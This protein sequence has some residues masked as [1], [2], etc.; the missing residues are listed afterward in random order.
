MDTVAL[1]TTTRAALVTVVPAHSKID[2]AGG[3]GFGGGHAAGLT[4]WMYR[5]QHELS[6]AIRVMPA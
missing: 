6:P 2:T 1:G 4:T 5:L 3:F